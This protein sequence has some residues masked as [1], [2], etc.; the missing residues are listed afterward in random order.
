[1]STPARRFATRRG[2]SLLEL[3]IVVAIIATVSALAIPRYVSALN[4]YRAGAL[5]QRIVADLNYIAADA[6]ASSAERWVWFVPDQWYL[7]ISAPDPNRTNDSYY[8]VQTSLEPYRAYILK[9]SFE[10][11]Q[12]FTFDGYGKPDRSGTIV[13]GSGDETRT[14]TLDKATGKASV[15]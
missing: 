3:V 2:F 4:R 15:Q 13:V 8:L 11:E 7:A 9:V 1:M 12:T 10:G 14:I 6:K 5:A